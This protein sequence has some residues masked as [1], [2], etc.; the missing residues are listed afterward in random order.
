[1]MSDL[2][3]ILLFVLF[4]VPGSL[5]FLFSSLILI[6]GISDTTL[7]GVEKLK[8]WLYIFVFIASPFVFFL[9]HLIPLPTTGVFP[10]LFFIIEIL[11]MFGVPFVIFRYVKSYYANRTTANQ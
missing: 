5:I 4:A 1:M 3:R 7:L 11:A 2:K 9:F 6:L 10:F 8:Q